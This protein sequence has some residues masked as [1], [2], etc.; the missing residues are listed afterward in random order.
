MGPVFC[1]IESFLRLEKVRE[2]GKRREPDT[3]FHFSLYLDSFWCFQLLTRAH[4]SQSL[5]SLE[6]SA[7]NSGLILNSSILSPSALFE[8]RK[9]S[10]M[11]PSCSFFCP[12]IQHIPIVFATYLASTSA[13]AICVLALCGRDWD[14]QM[15]DMFHHCLFER[16]LESFRCFSIYCSPAYNSRRDARTLFLL[17]INLNNR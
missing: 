12:N 8:C 10:T 13:R 3:F 15:T 5:Y 4:G 11:L 7:A 17:L 1:I 6:E 16:Y 14:C 2:H 9:T